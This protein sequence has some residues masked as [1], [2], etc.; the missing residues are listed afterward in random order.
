MNS[1]NPFELPITVRGYEMDAFG[2]VNH[3]VY[4]QYFEHCRWMAMRQWSQQWMDA[5][6][7]VVKKLTIEYEAP[8]RVFD[9]LMARLWV[10]EIG[11]TSVVFGQDLRRSDDDSV[12]ARGEVVAVCIDGSGSPCPVPDSW[13]QVLED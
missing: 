12:V 5:G 4:A 8:A 3:A 11:R 1:Q 13:R 9:E 7:I 10:D 2:H 6:G